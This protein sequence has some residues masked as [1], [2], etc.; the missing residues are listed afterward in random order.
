MNQLLKL[1]DDNR[2]A[3]RKYEIRATSK[4]EAE[5]LVYDVIGGF[6][7]IDAGRFV[8]DLKA[9]KAETI[10]L[11]INSPG[12]E[13][14]AARAIQTALAQH[15]AQV[16]AHIDGLAASA[17]TVVMLAANKIIASAGAFVMVHNPW[18]LTIGDAEAH[19]AS[20]GLLDKYADA[21]AGDYQRRT[22]K[23]EATVREWMNAETWFTAAEAVDAGLVDEVEE[24]VAAKNEWNLSAYANVPEALTSVHAI[25]QATPGAT[26][27]QN[28]VEGAAPE[29]E[30][31]KEVQNMEPTNTGQQTAPD[32]EAVRAEAIKAERERVSQI[33]AIAAKHGMD[34]AFVTA[35]IE[36]SLSVDQVRAK[37]LD[38]LA[39]KGDEANV[40]GASGAATMTHDEADKRR[41]MGVEAVLARVNPAQFKADP[42]N[43]LKHMS[44]L[45][46][47]EECCVRN[48]LSV[49]GKS[50]T[51]LAV[52]AMHSTSDFPYILENSM[53][54]V[55]LRTYELA[56]PSY[57]QWA[58][59]GTASDF[60]TMSRVRIGEAP[61]LEL[62]PE[63]GE[64]KMGTISESRETYAIGTYGKGV[65]FTRQMIIN[66][67]LGAFNDIAGAFGAQAA[68]LE[69]KTVYTILNTNGNMADNVALFHADHFNLGTGAI[70]NTG[71]DAGVVAMGRQVGLDGVSILNLQPKYLIVPLSKK[72]TAMQAMRE[73]GPS[74]KI[75]DQ[76]QFA[77]AFDVVA[78]GELDGT[79]TSVWYFAA[80][81][82]IAPLIEYA[83]LE[84]AEGPQFIR[85]EN[86]GGIL[87]LKFYA[88]IDFGAK[89][90]DWRGGYK[91]SGV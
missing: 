24:T 15:P 77:G 48:S 44:L 34:Q 27:A 39:A 55:L 51:E 62:V 58:K 41:E 84:G 88:F 36:G 20:A 5:V 11:R 31:P 40:R 65:S 66:D 67:D 50:A 26:A 73:T 82:S 33:R 59:K 45:R 60:K 9:I 72:V 21:L 30:K 68:R 56:T 37:V 78:D 80:D 10:H 43:E 75:A 85:E 86:A 53:R 49:R 46:L 61:T 32:M 23:D 83:H 12:G 7:G 6:Y 47:A 1:Y 76:N 54:K 28:E 70:G 18:G 63:G 29:T 90:I 13:V 8:K 74:L 25:A 19:R 42:Q 16:I 91:S 14:N 17:A 35:A 57:R 4:T 89:A 71:L 81:P 38:V 64:I 87:G 22:G 52:M 79:S 3:P 69:N 2:E